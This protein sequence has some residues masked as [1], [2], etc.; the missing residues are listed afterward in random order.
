MIKFVKFQTFQG[1]IRTIIVIR[2][3]ND[4]DVASTF[5]IIRKLANIYLSDLI[6]QPGSHLESFLEKRG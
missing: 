4:R 6:K 3:L 5:C 2:E 1:N